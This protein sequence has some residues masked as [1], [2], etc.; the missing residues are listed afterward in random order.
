MEIQ[1]LQVE[2]V[3]EAGD[4]GGGDEHRGGRGRGRA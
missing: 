2:R 1:V 3:H 4:H